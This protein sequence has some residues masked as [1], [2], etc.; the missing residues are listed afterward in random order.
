MKTYTVILLNPEA[1]QEDEGLSSFMAINSTSPQNAAR[2]A[3]LLTA[4]NL[5]NTIA[6]DFKV[7]AVFE[8]VI[9]PELQHEDM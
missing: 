3:Q 6:D 8:G 1:Y 5:A 2:S 4:N 7:I 9:Y